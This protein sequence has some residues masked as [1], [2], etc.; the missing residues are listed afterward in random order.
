M[1]A[2]H[3]VE[4]TRRPTPISNT[5]GQLNRHCFHNQ[6]Q[7]ASASR[8]AK[9]YLLGLD[10]IGLA[11]LN[12]STARLKLLRDPMALSLV[13]THGIPG[14]I[15][16]VPWRPNAPGFTMGLAG[17]DPIDA[18]YNMTGCHPHIDQRWRA[19]RWSGLLVVMRT[20]PPMHIPQCVTVETR[21]RR[22]T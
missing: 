19:Q 9:T 16:T 11:F 8:T 12:P 17:P 5:F 10:K 14:D 4:K 3:V 20:R 1:E 2:S 6:H 22:I 15:S 13:A 7:S 21:G 18:M